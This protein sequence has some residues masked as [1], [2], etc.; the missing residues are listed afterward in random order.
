MHLQRGDIHTLTHTHTKE[1]GSNNEKKRNIQ[2]SSSF[3]LCYSLSQDDVFVDRWLISFST[4]CNFFNI[5]CFSFFL[6]K[7]QKKAKI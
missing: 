5:F 1:K 2:L 4:S 6:P 7:F 3:F